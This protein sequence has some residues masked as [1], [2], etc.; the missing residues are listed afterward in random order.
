MKEEGVVRLEITL[1]VPPDE[2]IRLYTFPIPPK[3][4]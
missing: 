1:A 2:K 3:K 4:P